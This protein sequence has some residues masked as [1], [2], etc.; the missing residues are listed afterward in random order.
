MRS[1]AL[2]ALG[3]AVAVPVVAFL[4]YYVRPLRLAD[5]RA[6]LWISSHGHTSYDEYTTVGYVAKAIVFF[7]EPVPLLANVLT[8]CAYASVRRRPADALASI[9]VVVGANLTTQVLKQVLAH[10]RFE[11]FLSHPPDLDTFPS[12]HVTAAAS[13]VVALVWVASPTRRRLVARLGMAYIVLVGLSVLVLEWHFPSDAI[14]ALCVTGAWASA[15]L[16]AYLEI[17]RRRGLT[18]PPAASREAA[19]CREP[20]TNPPRTGSRSGPSPEKDSGSDRRPARAR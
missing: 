19:R 20:G 3:F 5:A 9:T 15:V 16:A 1:A 4:A 7:A 8:C 11:P 6:S 2:T 13:L 18:G 12:G 14:G 17:N 10:D